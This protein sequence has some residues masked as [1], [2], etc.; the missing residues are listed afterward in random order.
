MFSVCLPFEKP[1]QSA[2]MA[3]FL[4]HVLNRHHGIKNT[5]KNQIGKEICKSSQ[6]ADMILNIAGM[7][8]IIESVNVSAF[9]RRCGCLAG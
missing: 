5:W 8:R 2:S 7:V 4:Q 3:A 6:N 1:R 9:H